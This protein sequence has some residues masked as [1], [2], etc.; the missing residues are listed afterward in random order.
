[1]YHTGDCMVEGLEYWTCDPEALSPVLTTSGFVL[2]VP[3]ST[4][5]PHL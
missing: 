1:M 3:S 5:Q 4:P 2:E